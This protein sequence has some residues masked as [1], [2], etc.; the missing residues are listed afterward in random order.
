MIALS[1]RGVRFYRLSTR[2]V[3]GTIRAGLQKI[4]NGFGRCYRKG[5]GARAVIVVKQCFWPKTLGCSEPT[6]VR[7]GIVD[8]QLA[9]RR[10]SNGGPRTKLLAFSQSHNRPRAS[11]PRPQARTFFCGWG[12]RRS[13]WP[14]AC[15]KRLSS[16]FFD[17]PN[18]PHPE[19]GGG[20]NVVSAPVNTYGMMPSGHDG[21]ARF[22]P[23]LL[24][25]FV[26]PGKS[27][28]PRDCVTPQKNRAFKS[29]GHICGTDG[30]GG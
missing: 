26:V 28:H 14:G 21:V 27:Q 2:R 3:V 16:C 13:F 23:E 18:S 30:F 29:S 25:A 24:C 9:V 15:P 20:G 5:G 11:G 8:F 6:P 17:P 22:R 19:G 10:R 1:R 4:R 7:P 12:L